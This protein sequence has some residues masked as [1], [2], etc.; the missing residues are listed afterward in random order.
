[1]IEFELNARPLEYREVG[2][3]FVVHPEFHKLISTNN[4]LV[5]GPRG[6]GKTTMLKVLTPEA[7]KSWIPKT[8]EEKAIKDSIT[9]FG[10][11]VPLSRIFQD[12]LEARYNLS[13]LRKEQ[14]D[15][16]LFKIYFLNIVESVLELVFFLANEKSF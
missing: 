13:K 16:L 14:K 15:N 4:S 2:K 1:M 6:S 10:L 5:V 7:Q 12:D 9:F 11:Y 8:L 3:K